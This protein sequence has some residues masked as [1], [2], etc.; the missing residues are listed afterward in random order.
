MSVRFVFLPITLSCMRFIRSLFPLLSLLFLSACSFSLAADITPPPGAY[1]PPEVKSQTA[2]ATGPLYPLVP[3]NPLD[4][5]VI[6]ADQCAPCHG[7]TGKG[8]GSRASEL[9]NPVTAIGS[10]EVARESTPALWYT[11]VTQGNLERY[12]PPFSSLSDR[13]RWDV[14][15]YVYTLSAPS[16]IITHGRQLF[17]ANC[18]RCHGELGQGNGPEVASLSTPPR[19][20]TDQAFMSDQSEAKF[21]ET[22]TS[23]Q[24]S[25]PAFGS[26]LS[27]DDRWS[28]TA[29]LRSLTFATSTEPSALVPSTTT[30]II[31]PS[32]QGTTLPTVS[33]SVTATNT[34]FITGTITGQVINGTGGA[35]TKGLAVTLHGFDNMQK[36]ITETTSVNPSGVYTFTNTSMPNGRIFLATVDY[37]NTTYSSDF[38]AVEQGKPTLSLPVTVY[39]TTTDTSVLEVDRLHIFFDFTTPNQVKVGE[40]YIISNPT[41]KTIVST[42][43]GSPV[44]SFPLPQGAT[45]LQFQEGVLGDRYIQTPDG[46]ADTTPVHPNAGEYQVLFAFDLPYNR[47][48]SF[49]QSINMATNAAVVLLPEVGVKLNSGMLQDSGTRNVQNTVYHLYSG[50]NLSAGTPLALSLSGRPNSSSIFSSTETRDNLL[51]G[52]G[53]LGVTMIIAGVWLY[54]R[55]RETGMRKVKAGENYETI[56][57]QMESAPQDSATLMDAIIALDDLYQAGKLPDEA[58]RQRRNELK[59]RLKKVISG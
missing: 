4:G 19:I 37:S 8:V 53:A 59:E 7:I 40:L 58:Y 14:I 23:G 6:Y 38:T 48:L 3:P 12:M 51:I 5:A 34:Q 2:P 16:D 44:V 43:D 25:M 15:A 21:Y 28:L 26:Q 56:P 33:G 9:P 24:S 41:N 30:V 57:F 13:Q 10:P 27:D 54:L 52:L 35:L 22:I 46:F 55:S 50:N 39:E 31:T 45:N 42:K 49:V 36:V 11:I 18:A 29:Y 17:Q 32:A 47:K 20:L 1:P